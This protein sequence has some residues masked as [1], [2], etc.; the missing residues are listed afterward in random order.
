MAPSIAAKFG[1][2][3]YGPPGLAFI[4]YGILPELG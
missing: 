3:P 4:P 1:G 2:I